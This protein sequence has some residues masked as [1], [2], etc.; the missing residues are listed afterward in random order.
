MANSGIS[1]IDCVFDWCV[2]ALYAVA[3]RLGITYEEINVWLFCIVWP[4]ITFALVVAVIVLK[5][6]NSSLTKEMRTS[7]DEALIE[8]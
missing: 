8:L 1:W 6:K 4:A 2:V 3:G 7:T 5:K